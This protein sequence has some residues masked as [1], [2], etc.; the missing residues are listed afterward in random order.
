MRTEIQKERLHN[1][2]RVLNATPEHVLHMQSY[3]DD[4]S[5]CGTAH[6]LLG[7]A[8]ND[9]WFK[10]NSYL[11]LDEMALSETFGITP[12]QAEMLFALNVDYRM[13]PHAIG[14]AEVVEK[15]TA[16]IAR[17]RIRAY[18]AMRMRHPPLAERYKGASD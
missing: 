1:L 3:T 11:Q 18:E 2:L 16:L 6:C 12:S 15:L 9:E 4:D 13:D 14:K 10:E 7:W 17:K 5:H 8:N